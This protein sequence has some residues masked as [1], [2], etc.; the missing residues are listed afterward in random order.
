MTLPSLE[1]RTDQEYINFLTSTYHWQISG[2]FY[3]S[4]PQPRP[5]Y[6]QTHEADIKALHKFLLNTYILRDQFDQDH[7]QR[8]IFMKQLEQEN[9]ALLQWIDEHNK[10]RV[11]KITIVTGALWLIHEDLQQEFPV[12]YEQLAPVAQIQ[13][14]TRGYEKMP[15]DEKVAVVRKLDADTYRFLGELVK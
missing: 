5:H 11:T 10:L 12:L 3:T 4:A 9:P 2:P 1:L 6:I 8:R 15:F 7:A 13:F 14:D